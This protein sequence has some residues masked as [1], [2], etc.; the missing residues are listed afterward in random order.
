MLENS[1]YE[2]DVPAFYA[3]NLILNG[4]PKH[5]KMSTKDFSAYYPRTKLSLFDVFNIL[6]LLS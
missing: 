2:Y 3:L 4:T 6:G 1:K 5:N